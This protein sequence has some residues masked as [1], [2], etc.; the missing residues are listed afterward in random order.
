M[1]HYTTLEDLVGIEHCKLGFYQELQQK[2]EQ[3]KGSNLELEKKRKEIQ[4]LLDGITDLMVV[5]AE[6]LS[7]QRVNHVFTDWFPGIDPIGRFCYE[8]FR[9]QQGRCEDCP[10]L[11]AL[12]RDEIVKDLCIYKV[13]DDFKHYE[14]I[15]SPLKTSLTGERQVLLFKRDVTLEK[16]FQAQFYQAEKMATVGALAAGVAHE[17]NNPL[18]AINGF[19]QGLKRRISRLQGKIDDDLFCDFKEY[20]ETIIKECLRCRDIVQTLLTFSRPTASSRGHVNINQCVTDTL[21]IL[22]H[23]FKE[24]HDLTVKTELQEDLPAILGDES[25]LKQVIINLLTN[26]LDATSNGGLIQIKTY[27]DET[28]GVTLVI[29]DSGCGIP[30]ELQDKLF[31]PFFTTKPVGKGIGIGLSTCYSI[32]KNHNGEINVT[33]VVGTGSAFRVSLPGINEEWTKKDTPSW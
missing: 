1:P 22:K 30:L 29:E 25:Q 19:A 10:A 2:V 3:L 27:S 7:I 6:D 15:A 20:T 16:E 26:A 21:F 9:G 12:D 4:A 33:S 28:A 5:L 17:I 24:Q 11:H 8:I 14:I 13:N 31:E 23:H 18:T 32:V